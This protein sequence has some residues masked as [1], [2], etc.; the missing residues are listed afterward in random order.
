VARYTQWYAFR[1]VRPEYAEPPHYYGGEWSRYGASGNIGEATFSFD[2]LERLWYDSQTINNKPA[3]RQFLRRPNCDSFNDGVIRTGWNQQAGPGGA[4]G[5]RVDPNPSDDFTPWCPTI[6]SDYDFRSPS[7]IFHPMSTGIGWHDTYTSTHLMRNLD[8]ANE[9]F[10][11][12]LRVGPRD[13]NDEYWTAGVQIY[14]GAEPKNRLEVG[15]TYDTGAGGRTL[16]FAVTYYDPAPVAAWKTHS[17]FGSFVLDSDDWP[18]ELMIKRKNTGGSVEFQMWYRICGPYGWQNWTEFADFNPEDYWD[19]N[20]TDMTVSVYAGAFG[21]TFGASNKGCK[22]SDFEVGNPDTS[23]M[24]AHLEN[25]AIVW[26]AV[27]SG[28]TNALWLLEEFEASPTANAEFAYDVNNSG[29]PSWSSWKTIA[30]MQ[31]EDDEHGR[32]FH[33]KARLLAETSPTPTPLRGR[34]G[35]WFDFDP[36]NTPEFTYATIKFAQGPDIDFEASPTS[37]DAPPLI[38]QFTP[39]FNEP[40][41]GCFWDFGDGSDMSSED[42]PSHTYTASGKYSP[43]LTAWNTDGQTT[44]EKAGLIDIGYPPEGITA[45]FEASPTEG[46][47][48]VRV[49]FYDR[50]DMVV[51]EASWTFGDA[52]T[53]DRFNPTH[54]YSGAGN[55]TVSYTATD[56]DGNSDNETKAEYISVSERPK[57]P[58]A[59]FDWEGSPPSDGGRVPYKVNFA[60]KSSGEPTCWLWDFGD[61]SSPSANQNPSHNYSTAGR[62]DVTLTAANANGSDSVTLQDIVHVVE[63]SPVA[64]NLD[65]NKSYGRSVWH[66]PKGEELMSGSWNLVEDVEHLNFGFLREAGCGTG[67]LIVAREWANRNQIE[68]GDS[69]AVM[70]HN[71][72]DPYNPPPEDAFW[73]LQAWYLGYVDQ[74]KADI[75]NGTVE[76]ALVGYSRHL[77]DI[78]PGGND[79]DDSPIFYCS[80][81]TL[82]TEIDPEDPMIW[83]QHIHETTVKISEIVLDLYDRYLVP[84][85][86]F[87]DGTEPDI[88][89]TPDET[90]LKYLKLEGE[91][92][93]MDVL[94]MLGRLAGGWTWGMDVEEHWT[95][96][97][98][99]EAVDYVYPRFFFKQPTSVSWCAVQVAD[100]LEEVKE[101]ISKKYLYNV[102]YLE[103][104]YYWG[105]MPFVTR[106]K[107]TF[108]DEGSIVRYG[109]RRIALTVPEIKDNVTAERYADWLFSEYARPQKFLMV[110]QLGGEKRVVPWRRNFPWG[111]S[112]ED[113][114]GGLLEVKDSAGTLIGV[115]DYQEARCTFNDCAEWIVEVGPRDPK[116]RAGA[117]GLAELFWPKLA[118]FRGPAQQDYRPV[119]LGYARVL[120]ATYDEEFKDYLYT[121]L[122]IQDPEGNP[123]ENAAKVDG[124]YNI[125]SILVLPGTDGRCAR[126]LE[127]ESIVA[128]YRG[129]DLRTKQAYYYIAEDAHKLMVHSKLINQGVRATWT[130]EVEIP[131][132]SALYKGL[133]EY[134]EA[135]TSMA[136]AGG[137]NRPYWDITVTWDYDPENPKMILTGKTV[138]GAS[139]STNYYANVWFL[140]HTPKRSDI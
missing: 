128:Y 39:T 100:R 111:V 135:P 7:L 82:E 18:I 84:L 89:E 138:D 117:S 24:E 12:A 45:D 139:R 132:E 108:Y 3:L 40:V 87:P 123:R 124:V 74:V 95:T 46:Y 69:I 17:D 15:V 99:E 71:T 29:T 122:P 58:G 133:V 65:P 94:E 78:Y 27:D 137:M 50:S 79:E 55:Y 109:R 105:S 26:P 80:T 28:N 34:Y 126:Y 56:L 10:Y 81:A 52:Y 1:Y 90:D 59:A 104:S 11:A 49:R 113:I 97:G 85:G 106:Y 63:S 118:P 73:G 96:S 31:A 48:P 136:F 115:Y 9:D 38:V 91:R 25:T 116:L 140:G 54:V 33:L 112:E 134:H 101:S 42:A 72:Q 14:L 86:I 66:V 77:S 120:S 2:E 129:W 114:R 51:N 16:Y 131:E 102:L 88:D 36:E 22:F 121:I 70:H 32:Y 110:K 119:F 130:H 93:L 20:S 41:I 75:T 23:K 43:R 47:A 64:N 53:S 19:L 67:R 57:V 127:P 60:D 5:E 76:Y 62:F 21:Y 103:G 125:M 61:E 6:H 83:E 30:Q 37:A 92:N 13:A 107:D 44:V 35:Y 4:I 8:N 98:S 68:V